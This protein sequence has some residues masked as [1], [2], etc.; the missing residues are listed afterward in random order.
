MSIYDYSYTSIEGKEVSLAE[1]QGKV[2]LIV[3][4]ASECGFTYQYEGLEALYKKYQDKGF[5]V[6]GFPCNQFL[7]QEPS[8]NE[9]VHEFCKLRY[10]VTF[11]LSQK[12]EVRDENAIDLYK[13]LIKEKGFIDKNYHEKAAFLDKIYD[14]VLADDEIKWNFTKFLVDQKGNVVKRFEP[15]IE[16][17]E[18]E[19]DI[20]ALLK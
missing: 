9:E 8:S 3:N 19:E 10:G 4:T 17:S 20:E 6:I 12:V 18:I 5:V 2:I 15:Y 13:Y 1:Y 16:P 14:D 11:P 7:G